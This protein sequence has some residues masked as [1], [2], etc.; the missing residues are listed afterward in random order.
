[1]S[2]GWYGSVSCIAVIK[3]DA[4]EAKDLGAVGSLLRTG[5]GENID[6]GFRTCPR[7]RVIALR[8]G[9]QL[10]LRLGRIPVAGSS[11]GFLVA[12]DEP[13]WPLRVVGTNRED[14]R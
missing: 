2:L 10:I 11:P 14:T 7:R 8:D 12:T 1:M 3:A 5:L 6:R 4:S 9:S 13:L